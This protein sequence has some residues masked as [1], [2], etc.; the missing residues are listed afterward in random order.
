MDFILNIDIMRLAAGLLLLAIAVVAEL[1]DS[2]MTQIRINL[3]LR[4]LRIVL[5]T[6]GLLYVIYTYILMH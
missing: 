5:R 3:L 4:T 2:V 6:L 1:A